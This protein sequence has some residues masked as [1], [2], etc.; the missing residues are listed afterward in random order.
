MLQTSRIHLF[1]HELR[2]GVF[3]GD[4]TVLARKERVEYRPLLA[5]T[6]A[7][8]P[9][10]L[11]SKRFKS[12]GESTSTSSVPSRK[13][14][15]RESLCR[16]CSKWIRGGKHDNAVACNNWRLTHLQDYRAMC[17]ALG[18]EPAIPELHDFITPNTS[19]SAL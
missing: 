5:V 2:P 4:D 13:V 8:G 7:V 11:T 18:I 9:R 15:S 10:S 16:Q 6:K 14:A 12:L 1:Q 19:E 3:P 17:Q